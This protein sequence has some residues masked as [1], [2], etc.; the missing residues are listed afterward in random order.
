SNLFS[1]LDQVISQSRKGGMTFYTMDPR[2]LVATV[3]GG[4][5]SEV[6][7]R[8]AL[9]KPA[10]FEDPGASA[11]RLLSAQEGLRDLAAGTGGYAILNNNDLHVGL[12][13]AMS[14]NSSYYALAYY[15]NDLPDKEQ[16]RKVKIQVKGRP[17]LRVYSRTGYLWTGSTKGVQRLA[18]LSQQQKVTNALAATVPVRDLKVNIMQ[19][20][21]AKDEKTGDLTAKMAI[22]I[23]PRAWPFKTDG[24]D[25]LA[26][27]EVAGFAY[28]L[29]NKLI[30]GFSKNYS[31]R[32][33]PEVFSNVMK[34]GLN[35][36]EEIKL[37]K[38]GLY[39]LRIVVTDKDSGRLGSATEWVQAK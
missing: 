18:D 4:S 36:R 16:F 6:S 37:K 25:H 8:S 19:A 11:D 20:M 30:D 28:D 2:G 32:L 17:D 3:P 5:A 34:Q 38:R 7:G 27:F 15:P 23:D 13:K 24:S 33:K 10:P 9:S 22:S 39:S 12:R 21:V 35:L 29:G 14:Q 26:S 31:V 1:E